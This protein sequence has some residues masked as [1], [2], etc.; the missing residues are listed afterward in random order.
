MRCRLPFAAG[1]YHAKEMVKERGGSKD[2]VEDV[3][4]GSVRL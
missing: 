4:N 1:I 3:E 2:V